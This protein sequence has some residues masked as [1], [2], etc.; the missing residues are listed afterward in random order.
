MVAGCFA[1]KDNAVKLVLALKQKGF[2][3]EI[4]DE[5]GGLTR[6]SYNSYATKQDASMALNKIK[7]SGSGAWILNK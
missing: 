3:A 4:I 7:A 5:V 1:N 6:V 2:G